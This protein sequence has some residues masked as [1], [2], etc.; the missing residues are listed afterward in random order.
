[1]SWLHLWPPSPVLHLDLSTHHFQLG[2]TLPR[3]HRGPS[4]LRLCL[5]PSCLQFR[6]DQSL[7]LLRHGLPGLW[8]RLVSQPLQLHQAPPSLRLHRCPH[9]SLVW[10]ICKKKERMKS[11]MGVDFRIKNKL[12]CSGTQQNTFFFL[13]R[14][15]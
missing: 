2:S 4:S 8:L 14:V 13:K 15:L 3:L 10:F 5:V 7:P 1:M 12:P 6:L 9:Y 11:N